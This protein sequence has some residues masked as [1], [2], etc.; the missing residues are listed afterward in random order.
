MMPLAARQT[1]KATGAPPLP[2]S[3][4]AKKACYV[5]MC[6]VCERVRG[7]VRVKGGGGLRVC[8]C[9]CVC[10][11]VGFPGPKS[12]PCMHSLPLPQPWC[13]VVLAYVD[14]TL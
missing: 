10:E 11:Y 12:V 4:S 2:P 8:V 6:Y 14:G 7:G 5:C 13:G 3:R 1:Q 9:V